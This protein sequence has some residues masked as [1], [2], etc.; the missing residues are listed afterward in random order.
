MRADREAGREVA[1]DRRQPGAPRDADR[2]GGGEDD[3]QGLGQE[4]IRQRPKSPTSPRDPAYDWRR[5]DRVLRGLRRY[6]LTPVLTL[7]GTPAWANGPQ[8]SSAIA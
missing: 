2:A 1:D 4:R 5:A 3:D 6:G 7:V 8:I